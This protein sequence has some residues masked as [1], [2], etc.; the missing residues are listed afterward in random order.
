MKAI[1]Y[2]SNAGT[3]EEYARLLGKKI[4]LPVYSLNDAITQV[5]SASE[6]IYLGWLMAGGI[7]GY[8]TAVKKYKVCA[9]CAV[10]MGGTGTKTQAVR[11]KN[12]ISDSLPLFTLQGGFNIHKLHGVYKMMMNVVVKTAGKRLANKKDRTPDEDRMLEMMLHGGNYVSEENLKSVL[13]WYDK[14]KDLS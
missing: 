3:T 10:G 12:A 9:V 13:E 1:I 11:K 7:K 8:K 14:E 2:T 5:E 6:I 4:G